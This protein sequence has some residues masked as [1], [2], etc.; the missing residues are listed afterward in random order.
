[1]KWLL[2]DFGVLETDEVSVPFT[3]SA[4]SCQDNLEGFLVAI[5][6]DEPMVIRE[7][8]AFPLWIEKMIA[9]IIWRAQGIR[10]GATPSM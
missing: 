6:V 2:L 10:K 9:R 7:R 3:L 8:T 4:D 5:V 1:L